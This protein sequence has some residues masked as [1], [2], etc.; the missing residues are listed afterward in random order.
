[1]NESHESSQKL[2]GV[3]IISFTGPGAG[4]IVLSNLIDV[5][6]ALSHEIH[7]FSISHE[8]FFFKDDQG[9]H[10]H[11]LEYKPGSNILSRIVKNI[12]LQLRISYQLARMARKIDL[13]IFFMAGYGLVLPMI[14]VR[15][16]RKKV[17]LALTGSQVD[18][19][20][21]RND[22]LWRELK[23]LVETGYSLSDRIIIYSENV[24]KE[25]N[26][27]KYRNKISIAHEHFLDF[28]KFQIQKPL[29]ERDNVIGYIGRLSEEKG[30]LNLMEA[31]SQVA[32]KRD[33]VAFL[34]GGD[35]QLRPQV[36]EYATKL[37]NKVKFVGWIA[38]DELPEYLNKLK[39]LVLPS[40]TEGLPNIMLEAMACGTPVLATPVG[41]IPD[42]IKDGETGFI[43]ENNS[44]ECI[45]E[46][47]VRALDYPT[48][49]QI[50][51]NARTLVEKEF[52][53]QAA[54]AGY[55]RILNLE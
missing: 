19:A 37:N 43:M 27:K 12:F 9:L 7:V 52:T 17:I 23:F 29:S 45:A 13:C 40:Y 55:R 5:L 32:E 1:M 4:E 22:P 25:L 36:E 3:G 24:A 44:P 2:N 47:I 15:A 28:D 53:Y 26:L 31:I 41:A 49:E 10:I 46:D 38:H 6:Q 20:K 51:R 50:T 42:V 16:C 18:D 8:R 30:T 48:Q 11:N 54:V 14:A 33:E 34:I 39:L 35:G 21:A